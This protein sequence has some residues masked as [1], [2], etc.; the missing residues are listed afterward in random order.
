[1]DGYME[2]LRE[3]WLLGWWDEE[4]GSDLKEVLLSGNYGGVP[5]Y[6]LDAPQ[7]LDPL[8]ASPSCGDSLR[9]IPASDQK[10]VPKQPLDSPVTPRRQSTQFRFSQFVAKKGNERKHKLSMYTAQAQQAWKQSD[11]SVFF[12]FKKLGG[13]RL[14]DV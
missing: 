7:F 6:P 4:M 8:P 9:F 12:F 2:D 10:K 13:T 1:M 5:S 14:P 11:Y 3:G